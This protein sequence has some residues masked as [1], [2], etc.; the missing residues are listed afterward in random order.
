MF[1]SS[2]FEEVVNLIKEWEPKKKYSY[3]SKYRDDLLKFLR[4]K[5]NRNEGFFGIRLYQYQRLSITKEDGRGLCDIA[6]NKEIGIEIKKD[7]KNKSQVDR[8]IGQIIGYKKEY[9]D[10]II[11][12]VGNT[13]DD[14]VES[15]RNTI[16]DLYPN[17]LSINLRSQR[18]KIINK[19]IK[20][21]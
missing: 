17:T 14:M 1:R 9:Q 16:V 13:N 21:R 15:L 4:E 7:L 5:L 3:E 12:L 11:V 8:L 6:I 18:V 10:L 19:S 2:L 20:N